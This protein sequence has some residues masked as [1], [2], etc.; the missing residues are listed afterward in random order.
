M[1]GLYVTRRIDSHRIHCLPMGRYVF[2]DFVEFGIDGV[3]ASPMNAVPPVHVRNPIFFRP[4]LSSVLPSLDLI[5]DGCGN[6]V[7]HFPNESI[8]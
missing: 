1:G 8:H 4:L 5:P 3:R 7:V 6:P 2:C